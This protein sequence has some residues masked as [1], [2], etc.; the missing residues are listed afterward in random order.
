MNGL[1]RQMS[2]F[3]ERGVISLLHPVS[4]SLDGYNRLQPE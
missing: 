3:P 4:H 2:S 1:K